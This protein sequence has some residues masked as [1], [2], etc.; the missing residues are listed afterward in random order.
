MKLRI[1]LN[2]FTWPMSRVTVSFIV[3]TGILLRVKGVLLITMLGQQVLITIVIGK[4]LI[5]GPGHLASSRSGPS[6]PLPLAHAISV[7]FLFLQGVRLFTA[8]APV[9]ITALIS[10][11]SVLRGVHSNRSLYIICA[12]EFTLCTWH[13]CRDAQ[14]VFVTCLFRSI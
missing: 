3:Q 9:P 13:R 6:L 4:L 5:K 1:Y 7:L 10:E 12:S 8:P 2:L 14:S 11:L